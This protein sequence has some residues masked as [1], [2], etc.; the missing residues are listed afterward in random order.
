MNKNF[1]QRSRGAV[2]NNKIMAK[3]RNAMKFKQ[4]S[5]QQM[6]I[7]QMKERDQVNMYGGLGRV[8]LDYGKDFSD[9]EFAEE[10]DQK[11]KAPIFSSSVKFEP[12]LDDEEML[13]E[14]FDEMIDMIK[15][16][17]DEF[18]DIEVD[19]NDIDKAAYEVPDSD[20][21]YLR[22]LKE[23]FGFDSFKEGQLDAIKIMIAQR[24]NALVVLATGGGKSLIYQFVSQFRPGL[25]LVVSPLLALMEDQLRKLPEFMP[26]AQINST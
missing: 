4:R 1:Q 24:D 25:I 15:Q 7:D 20:E 19:I 13:A 5:Y 22:I 23:R 17:D 26:G 16:A 14:D 21:G 8:G 10:K 12:K 9:E 11:E 18:E 3:K 6:K 2:Y